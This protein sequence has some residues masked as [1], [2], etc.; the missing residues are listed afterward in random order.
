MLT[1]LF[2]SSLI[3]VSERTQQTL[4][5]SPS[6]PFHYLSTSIKLQKVSDDTSAAHQL[7]GH[8][9]GNIPRR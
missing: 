8:Q 6:L 9:E 3:P 5:Q 7:K 2:Q 4:T 1:W